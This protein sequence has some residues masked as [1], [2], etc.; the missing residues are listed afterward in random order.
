MIEISVL[1]AM[2]AA[3]AGVDAI[4]AAIEA[5]QKQEEEKRAARREGNRQRQ[6]KH[7][8]AN[9][10]LH[11][12]TSKKMNENND[13]VTLVTPSPLETPIKNLDS[14]ILD[15]AGAKPEEKKEG[16]GYSSFDGS[17]SFS[18]AE[19]T[20]IGLDFYTLTN[21]YG[22]IRT[23]AETNWVGSMRPSDRKR[24]IFNK[25]KKTHNDRLRNFAPDP[26]EQKKASIAAAHDEYAEQ[27]RRLAVRKQLT[28]V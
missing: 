17:V 23:L 24:A 8:N 1:R 4:I 18:A 5:D 13:R 22:Q 11:S 28:G 7:R 19:I 12:V 6:I 21:V 16:F 15:F 2:A 26:A 25:L 20:K 27:Q 14:K 3:G 9:N 10:A